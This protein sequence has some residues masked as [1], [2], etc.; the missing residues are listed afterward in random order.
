MLKFF[1]KYR[2]MDRKNKYL[3]VF[4]DFDF[5]RKE[6]KFQD[7]FQWIHDNE[8]KSEEELEELYVT[9]RDMKNNFKAMNIDLLDITTWPQHIFNG[10]KNRMT[11]DELKSFGED[12]DIKE[13]N[14][15]EEDFIDLIGEINLIQRTNKFIRNARGM[16]VL[17]E[18]DQKI[19]KQFLPYN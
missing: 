4:E 17:A 9:L 14:I 6:K 19:V 2:D 3:M 18:P 5:L 12:G 7:V 8:K 16:S 1:E 15:K 10:I 11:D 13:Y